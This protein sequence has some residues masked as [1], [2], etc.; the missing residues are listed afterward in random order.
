MPRQVNRCCEPK[1]L[2]YDLVPMSGALVLR[3]DGQPIALVDN[4]LAPLSA[5][6]ALGPSVESGTASGSM[7]P[8]G[9]AAAAAAVVAA[10]G[11]WHGTPP[12]SPDAAYAAARR[13]PWPSPGLAVRVR[14]FYVV[15]IVSVEPFVMVALRSCLVYR[16]H[17]FSVLITAYVHVQPASAVLPV[18]WVIGVRSI[19]SLS[20][21]QLPW[22]H[23]SHPCT[24]R[25]PVTGPIAAP[26][27]R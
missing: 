3:A 5:A 8:T 16:E 6:P 11:N 26:C 18:L 24:N 23:Y 21:V 1:V 20:F 17:P 15:C 25:T 9:L 14:A 27:S 22:F 13:L 2:S 7:L 12:A 4:V 19:H 10:D